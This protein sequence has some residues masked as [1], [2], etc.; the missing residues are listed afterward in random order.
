MR[1][2][3][4]PSARGAGANRP[5]RLHAGVEQVSYA[6]LRHSGLT[7]DERDMNPQ[8]KEAGVTLPSL[9]LG[10]STPAW[11]ARVR[12]SRTRANVNSRTLS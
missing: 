3:F 10:R 2:Q 1:F 5:T 8:E 11:T 12:Q 4:A 7:C 6:S 9:S